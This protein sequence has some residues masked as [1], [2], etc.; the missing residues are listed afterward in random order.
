MGQK[1]TKIINKYWRKK[2]KD[3][4]KSMP[5]PYEKK[6]LWDRIREIFVKK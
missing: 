4:G 5:L 2:K 3:G 6:T 1:I